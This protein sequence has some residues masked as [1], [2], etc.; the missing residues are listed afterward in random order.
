V[1]KR[2]AVD[3]AQ[4]GQILAEEL[5]RQDGVLLAGRGAEITEGLIRLLGRMNIDTVVI[6]EAERRT[7]EDIQAEHQAELSRVER[8]FRRAGD[9]AVLRALKKTLIF[10]SEQERDKALAFLELS[11]QP[12]VPGEAE[13]ASGPAAAD[14]KEAVKA[15]AKA[16]VRPAAKSGPKAE[17]HAPAK[18]GA[19]TASFAGGAP[20]T[21]T[22]A[23]PVP[24]AAGAAQ[25]PSPGR[26]GGKAR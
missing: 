23:P 14:V 4:P 6:E 13:A 1:A 5:K 3:Q 11:E 8:V 10:M 2:I 25:S 18:A 9:S 24:K 20:E 21:K 15:Q 16:P 19:G 17:G 22:G 26:S 12:D 7:R